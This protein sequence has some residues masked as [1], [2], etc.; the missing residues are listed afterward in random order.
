M[1]ELLAPAGGKEHFLAAVDSGADAVYFG[2]KRFSARNS[3]EN[4]DFEQLDY[5]LKYAKTFG[6]R[7][8]AAM[9]T[10]V[11]DSERKD[12]IETVLRL[13][14]MGVDGFIVQVIFLAKRINAEIP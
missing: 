6:V 8:Y 11:K 2:L 4:F 3:A 14:E 13:Y 12:F 1:L 7:A 5:C 9:N 10:L